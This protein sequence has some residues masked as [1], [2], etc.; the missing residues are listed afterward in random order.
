M[1]KKLVIKAFVFIIDDY[2][3]LKQTSKWLTELQLI[4]GLGSL[5]Y[6]FEEDE[7][8]PELENNKL[9]LIQKVTEV[10]YH[11]DECDIGIVFY[12]DTL[13]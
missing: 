5:F 10:W 12:G 7:V 1:R 9:Y 6:I 11:R 13:Y 8:I 4:P 3:C 2:V